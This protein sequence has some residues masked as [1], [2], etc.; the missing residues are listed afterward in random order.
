M[1]PVYWS[2]TKITSGLN[3]PKGIVSFSATTNQSAVPFSSPVIAG[4]LRAC[5][6]SGGYDSMGIV[7]YYW[8]IGLP[9]GP[10][11]SNNRWP[12]HCMEVDLSTDWL[13]L[14]TLFPSPFSSSTVFHRRCYRRRSSSGA[15]SV[16]PPLILLHSVIHYIGFSFILSAVT[17]QSFFV[18]TTDDRFTI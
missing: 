17:V 14:S 1:V 18:L 15:Q 12:T 7:R 3:T 16:V 6:V 8:C 11:K 10:L 2:I 13:H 4:P 5:P 9:C